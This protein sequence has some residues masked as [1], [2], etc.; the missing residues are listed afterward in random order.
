MSRPFRQAP[1]PSLLAD[2]PAVLRVTLVFTLSLVGFGALG[3]PAAGTVAVAVSLGLLLWLRVRQAQPWSW[4]GLEAPSSIPRLALHSALALI[5]GWVAALAALVLARQVFG[6][7]PMDASRFADVQGNLVALAGMLAISWS[8]A[9]FGEEVLFRGFLQQ[10]L[11]EWFSALPAGGLLA[12]LAQALLF[13]L[14]HAYQGATGI[15]VS[16]SIGLAFGLLRLRLRSVWPLVIAHG[17]IDTVS[18]LALYLG[19]RPG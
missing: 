11:R 18:M 10:R 2:P 8:T 17:L 6:W 19:A 3:L 14:G 16:A 9:A 5:L 12:V 7:A 13:G 4:L 15:L 1:L